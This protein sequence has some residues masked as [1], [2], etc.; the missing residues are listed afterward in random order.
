MSIWPVARSTHIF[1]SE[2][3]H[4]A[5]FSLI[6]LWQ[7]FVQPWRSRPEKPLSASLVSVAHPEAAAA[8][9]AEGSVAERERIHGVYQQAYTALDP[10]IERL[11]FDGKTPPEG[12]AWAQI[13]CIQAQA[14]CTALAAQQRS[15]NGDSPPH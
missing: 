4:M 7:R 3:K 13:A 6:A 12:A 11:M 10:L 2:G 1:E 14:S 5:L 15:E 8:L 9:R